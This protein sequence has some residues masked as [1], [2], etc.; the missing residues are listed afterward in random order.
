MIV[1]CLCECVMMMATRMMMN[2]DVRT[3]DGHNGVSVAHNDVH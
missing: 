1:L 3:Y 2:V